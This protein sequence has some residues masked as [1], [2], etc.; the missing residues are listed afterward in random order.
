MLELAL[1]Q[2]GKVLRPAAGVP[3]VSAPPPAPDPQSDGLADVLAISSVVP[4]YDRRVQDRAH[5]WHINDSMVFDAV[6]QRTYKG[7]QRMT[8]G[9]QVV[10][11]YGTDGAL[12]STVV[13]NDNSA[14]A[15]IPDDHNAPALKLFDGQLYVGYAG[16]NDDLNIYVRASSD[17]TPENLGPP[18][19]L[20]NEQSTT[21]VQFAEL[22]GLLYVAG[23]KGVQFWKLHQL[24][25]G[26][27]VSV[28]DISESPSQTYINLRAGGGSLR[29]VAWDHPT[30]SEEPQRGEIKLRAFAP[31]DPVVLLQDLVTVYDPGAGK[32]TRVLSVAPDGAVFAFA[33]FTVGQ[34]SG[35][36]Y[37]LLRWSGVGSYDDPAQWT[38][39]DI[40]GND[41]AFYVSS[42]YV[43]GVALANPDGTAVWVCEATATGVTTV[44]YG[45]RAGDGTWTFVDVASSNRPLVRPVCDPQAMGQVWIER[46]ERYADFRD[47]EIDN[48][49]LFTEDR[50]ENA[51][52]TAPPPPVQGVKATQVFEYF[53]A[54]DL[55]TVSWTA[56]LSAAQDGDLLVAAYVYRANQSSDLS[57]GWGP[58]Y[59]ARRYRSRRHPRLCC[60]RGPI[61]RVWAIN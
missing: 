17:T 42:N 45:T 61:R 3:E 5:S 10:D 53:D 41:Y 27:W 1:S 36:T 52:F 4:V 48:Y 11:I 32:G 58:V 33:E 13:I 9:A 21:Y 59:R 35:Q 16:H 6:T 2:G 38:R 30:G 18:A 22:D 47:A 46:L 54:P 28:G 34:T 60:G 39:E 15:F 40:G 43:P 23:R 24:V 31:G 26:S 37:H 29:Y 56:D 51:D 57:L 7:S 20:S 12:Q 55:A 44:R 25:N 50:I 19:T 14:T 49:V 8:D